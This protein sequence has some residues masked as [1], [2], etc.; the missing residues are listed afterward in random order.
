MLFSLTEVSGNRK[1]GKI[2]VSKA[3]SDTCP[4][5]CGMWFFCYGKAHWLKKHWDRLDQGAGKTF[6]EYLLDVRRKAEGIWRYGEVGDLPGKG[7]KIN[8]DMLSALT[9]ANR[10]KE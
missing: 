7:N 2:A 9:T 8:S 10:G 5:S 1:T 4:P 6:N 3:S